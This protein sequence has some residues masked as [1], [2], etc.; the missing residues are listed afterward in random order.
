[1]A[2]SLFN[3]QGLPL[4]A[5]ILT[6]VF[7]FGLNINNSFAQ[8]V[9]EEESV[10]GCVKGDT[11]FYAGSYHRALKE[12]MK[13]YSKGTK[14]KTN[15]ALILKIIESIVNEDMPQDTACYFVDRYMQLDTEDI[16]AYLLAA[17]ANYHSHRFDKAKK[18]LNEYMT[19]IQEGDQ[20]KEANELMKNINN[21]AKMVADSAKIH[22]VNMGEMINSP[23]NEIC[24]F[25]TKDN[26]VLYFSC[27][28]KFN[29]ADLINYYSI[30]FSENQDLSWTKS[31]MATGPINTLFDDYVT[32]IFDGGLMITSNR[33]GDFGIIE[34]KEK[35][36]AGKFATADKLIEPID[37]IGDEVGCTI[38][39]DTI[40][41]SATTANDK[42]DL[43]YSIRM[44]GKWSE[45]RPLP[46]EVNTEL[47]DE[48]YPN[49]SHDG[50][51]L[52]FASNNAET[53]MGGYD[54]YYSDLDPNEFKWGKPV[55]L[56]YPINDT[57][58]NMTISFT[59]DDRYAYISNVRKDSYGCRDIYC[60]IDPAKETTTAIMKC[61]V[62]IEMKPKP[63][64][65][66]QMP[67]IQVF[68]QDEEIV[69]TARLNLQTSTFIMALDPGV[70]TIR[71]Q[72][73]EAEDFESTIKVEEKVYSQDV[74]Q[75]I[76]L[77]S[78]T[79]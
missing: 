76:F 36:A 66:T 42:L 20:M 57:F 14:N 54:L 58:D 16:N 19:M 71:I 12:Y 11:Y 9:K 10:T 5:L 51:R 69:S 15:R 39:G 13:Y 40:I 3:K 56:P 45:A 8:K 79:E 52:F 33:Y 50:K 47:Y 55:Q 46:G 17:K 23:S 64:P 29:S 24:P 75:K 43:Y 35:G 37:L 53:S 21:A 72:S 25:I 41:F 4:K 38:K 49:L 27:D 63:R 22:L 78:A 1:M 67:L 73:P 48:N 61:F 18:Y 59:S 60:V 65:L 68:D 2:L 6:V 44:S 31:K 30:K 26:S 32:N 70:Y 74:I 7:S 77:L 62:G 28:E 34:C